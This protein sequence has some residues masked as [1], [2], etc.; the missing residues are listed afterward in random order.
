MKVSS[1]VAVDTN[2]GLDRQ[3]LQRVV[4]GALP[5]NVVCIMVFETTGSPKMPP[6]W[7]VAA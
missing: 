5:Q 7:R 3:W 6:L 4:A 1:A 2:V